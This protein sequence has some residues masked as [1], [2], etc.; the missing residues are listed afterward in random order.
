M[1]KIILVGWKYYSLMPP[2]DTQDYMAPSL[3]LSDLFLYSSIYTTQFKKYLSDQNS[4]L[5]YEV[6]R[7]HTGGVKA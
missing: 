2:H 4:P 7:V 5:V 3:L 1:F 6:Q